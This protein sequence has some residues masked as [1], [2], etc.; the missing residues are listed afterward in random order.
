LFAN[1]HPHLVADAL[2]IREILRV[3]TLR[4]QRRFQL[5][6]HDTCIANQCDVGGIIAVHDT[7][8]GVDVNELATRL[9]L[10]VHRRARLKPRTNRDHDLSVAQ[11]V[12]ERRL[13][14][15]RP[16]RQSVIL[17]NRAASVRAREYRRI[18]RFGELLH[19]GSRA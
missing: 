11:R 15:E 9:Q 14:G 18:Q 16:H 3:A 13:R 19:F 7:R 8:V 2:C 10:P 4:V 5:T 12:A 17:R 6:E 1:R